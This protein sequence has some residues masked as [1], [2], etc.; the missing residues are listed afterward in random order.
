MYVTNAFKSH[1]SNGDQTNPLER[2]LGVLLIMISNWKFLMQ[3][4]SKEFI[5]TSGYPWR[6]DTIRPCLQARVAAFGFQDIGFQDLGIWLWGPGLKDLDKRTLG[7]TLRTWVSGPRETGTGFHSQD[8]GFRTS[9]ALHPTVVL[10]F[11]RHFSLRPVSLLSRVQ[12]SLFSGVQFSRH[13]SLRPPSL[14]SASSGHWCSVYIAFRFCVVLWGFFKCDLK[15]DNVGC[16]I[17]I[18]WGSL[19]YFFI[20]TIIRRL[21]RLNGEHWKQQELT[22][23]STNPVLRF[24]LIGSFWGFWFEIATKKLQ[25]FSRSAW[26]LWPSLLWL[27]LWRYWRNYRQWL[28]YLIKKPEMPTNQQCMGGC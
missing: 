2:N 6:S 13:F 23:L 19:R 10:S 15:F 4:V 27:M 17:H 14:F 21:P 11:S 18:V 7:F 12:F 26:I 20:F 9:K 16:D 3:C 24:W 25:C 5:S 1:M 22:L 28:C 8:L